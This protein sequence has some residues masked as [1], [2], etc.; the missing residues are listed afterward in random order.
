MKTDVDPV[1]DYLRRLDKALSPLP[2]SRRKQLRAE[3]ADHIASACAE[4]PSPS[5]LQIRAVLNRIGSPEDIAAAELETQPDEIAQQSRLHEN[6]AIALLLF[7]GFFFVGWFVGVVLL[8]TSRV[9]RTRDKLLGT[10]VVPGGL[11]LPFFFLATIPSGSFTACSGTSETFV[12]TPGGLIPHGSTH[13]HCA[14]TGS[15]FLPGGVW[16][17][18]VLWAILALAPIFVAVHLYREER[19]RSAVS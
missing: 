17:A 7:G 8:W 3:I 16:F 5:E 18:V 2:R 9:W 14:T 11:A 13:T 10:L 4:L 1:E 19:R 6:F 12:S 15:P